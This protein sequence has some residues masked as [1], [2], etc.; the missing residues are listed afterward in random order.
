[1]MRD[2]ESPPEVRKSGHRLTDMIVSISAIVISVCSLALAIRHGETMERLVEVNSRPF[3]DF[4]VANG[5]LGVD[6]KFKREFSV[7]ISN[8]GSGSA[9]IETFEMALDGHTLSS[10]D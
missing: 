4:Q 1:M 9:R 8:P 2:T 3:I 6:G 10:W 5:R 7:G